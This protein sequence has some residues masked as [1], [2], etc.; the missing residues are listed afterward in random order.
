MDNFVDAARR[1]L[2]FPAEPVL[3][4]FQGLHKFFP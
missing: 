3:A 4:D 1:D 2:Q